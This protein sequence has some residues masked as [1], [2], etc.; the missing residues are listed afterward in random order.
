M[1]NLVKDFLKNIG[2]NPNREG[3]ID[4]P[5]RFVKTWKEITNGY[6]EDPDKIIKNAVFSDELE[7]MVILKDI[8]FYSMCEHHL[9]PFHGKCHIAYIPNGKILGLSKIVNLVEVYSKRL[10][11]Q[12]RL[13]RQIAE[14]L[15]KHLKPHGV[16][17]V[18]EA[19]H[20]C[21]TMRGIKKENAIA[22]TSCMLGDFRKEPE[23]RAEFLNLIK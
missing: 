4:T 6:N 1:E 17:I 18:M 10:Q 9:L 21:M 7:D 14:C 16:A 2:E 20:M 13:T 8:D 5:K 12:E 19:T 22:K 23:A 15:K 11:V 3:L